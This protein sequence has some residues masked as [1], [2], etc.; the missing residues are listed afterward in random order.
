MSQQPGQ[1]YLVN[2]R[3]LLP[4][5]CSEKTVIKMKHE[6]MGNKKIFLTMVTSVLFSISKPVT[7]SYLSNLIGEWE[8][9]T[10]SLRF[11]SKNLQTVI[12]PLDRGLIIQLKDSPEP[13]EKRDAYL[14]G[15]GLPKLTGAAL[16]PKKAGGGRNPPAG[17]FFPLLC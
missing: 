7:I 5:G 14:R 10:I 1:S 9:I 6:N 4:Q 17:W 8:N 12:H 2:G 16:N 13:S 15:Y 3:E 11:I